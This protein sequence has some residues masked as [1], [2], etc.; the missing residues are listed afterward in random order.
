MLQLV[1]R[2][3]A[4]ERGYRRYF[5]GKPCLAGHLSERATDR[6]NCI[7]CR[8]E[9]QRQ[10][11]AK[12]DK[13]A[14]RAEY[15]R[16][17][18]LTERDRIEAKNRAYQSA[19]AESVSAQKRAYRLANLEKVKQDRAKW[20]RENPHV[21]RA[22]N[23]ARKKLIRRATPPWVDR[24]A[25][26]AVYEQAH[27]LSLETGVEHHVDHI[28][29]IKGADVCGLHVP[30]NLRPLPWRENLSKKNKLVE[31]VVNLPCDDDQGRPRHFSAEGDDS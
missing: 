22:N 3:V 21:I 29:P 15:D 11:N 19:N 7:A 25:I 24:A 5:T 12:P 9:Q 14:A 1:P 17:R 2:S 27:R 28:V 30:W 8:R 23:A 26:L 4:R 6:K 10:A 20:A 16:Q 13:K 18:W 31:S